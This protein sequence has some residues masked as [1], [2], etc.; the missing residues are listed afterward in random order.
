[1]EL[2]ETRYIAP[3]LFG[4]VLLTLGCSDG[5]AVIPN[6]ITD[7]EYS[8]YSSWLRLHFKEQPSRLLLAS[9]TFIFDPIDRR[10]GA[11][12]PDGQARTSTSLL[13]ALHNLGEAVYPVR[14]DKFKRLPFKIPWDY[15]ESERLPEHP[16]QPF[17]LIA[18]SRV[19]FSQRRSEAFFAVSDS[20]GGLCGGGGALLAIRE[21]GEW[22]FKPDPICM[23][24]Y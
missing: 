23:W 2:I 24:I 1:M 3:L 22:T 7:E 12:T 18:F 11:T 17:R 5:A 14:T 13:R 21:Q 8:V 16:S 4:I 9:H 19:A 15:E 6:A 10:C 20:C